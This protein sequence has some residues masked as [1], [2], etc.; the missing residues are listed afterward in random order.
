MHHFFV[1]RFGIVVRD[2]IEHMFYHECVDDPPREL[3]HCHQPEVYE[4]LTLTQPQTQYGISSILLDPYS[5]LTLS[6]TS[7]NDMALY[8]LSYGDIF[9]NPSKLPSTLVEKYI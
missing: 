7:L 5:V 1:V 4:W 3:M 6:F 8:R 9:L 2:Y